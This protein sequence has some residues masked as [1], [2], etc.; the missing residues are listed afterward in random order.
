MTTTEYCFTSGKLATNDIRFIAGDGWPHHRVI[1]N[2]CGNAVTPNADGT[3][4]KHKRIHI[5]SK[6]EYAREKL[7]KFKAEHP[8]IL[9]PSY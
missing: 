1:C 4:R 7:A 3:M 2:E 6:G 8:D 9:V 5:A